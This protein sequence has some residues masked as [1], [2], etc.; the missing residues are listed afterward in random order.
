LVILTL[1][2]EK[3][4]FKA[5]NMSDSNIIFLREEPQKYW[6]TLVGDKM[7]CVNNGNK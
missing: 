1:L 6:C 5:P 7:C 4:V 2:E 3:D